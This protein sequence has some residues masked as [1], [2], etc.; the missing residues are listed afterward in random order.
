MNNEKPLEEINENLV[1]VLWDLMQHVNVSIELDLIID[2]L[3]ELGKKLSLYVDPEQNEKVVE[4][5]TYE[6]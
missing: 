1:D 5:E 3:E 4:E 2:A 6:F